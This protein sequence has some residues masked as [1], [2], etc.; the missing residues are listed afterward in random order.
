[1]DYA[2]MK[3]PSKIDVR[4]PLHRSAVNSN[5][6]WIQFKSILYIIWPHIRY[7]TLGSCICRFFQFQ[8][9]RLRLS[10][11]G[12]HC[13][14]GEGSR[15]GAASIRFGR[16]HSTEAFFCLHYVHHWLIWSVF[17]CQKTAF[18][19]VRRSACSGIVFL[20]T[21]TVRKCLLQQQGHCFPV[22]FCD[23]S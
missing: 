5:H 20:V 8:R 4:P 1:M 2:A 11:R 17:H 21:Q 15:P 9:Q 16:S 13:C 14:F 23:V 19:P 6:R 7:L 10:I 22:I 18:M 12:F 3:Y